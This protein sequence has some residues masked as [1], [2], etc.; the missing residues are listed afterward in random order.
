MSSSSNTTD[1]TGLDQSSV[2]TSLETLLARV[3]NMIVL[4]IHTKY[5]LLTNGFI[6][7]GY[8]Q[9]KTVKQF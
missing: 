2:F 4:S 1:T 5:Q 6:C 8:E 3:S 9:R 7:V